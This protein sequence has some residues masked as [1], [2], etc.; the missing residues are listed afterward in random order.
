VKAVF[1]IA[2]EFDP[3]ASDADKAREAV[4]L[5]LDNAL[6]GNEDVLDDYG[7]PTIGEA[8]DVL[9]QILR[10][11]DTDDAHYILREVYKHMGVPLP[12]FLE[13]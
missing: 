13:T 11:P 2:T 3:E 10:H 5:L 12:A 1:T 7:N 8:S 6:A 4:E 9:A